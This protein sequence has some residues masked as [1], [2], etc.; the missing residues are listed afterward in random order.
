MSGEPNIVPHFDRSTLS[1]LIPHLNP[2]KSSF[3]FSFW[4]TTKILLS[5]CHPLLE[6]INNSSFAYSIVYS[7]GLAEGSTFD[8][9]KVP[10]K[11]QSRH[12]C[13]H[14]SKSLTQGEPIP[15]RPCSLPLRALHDQVIRSCS[16]EGLTNLASLDQIFLMTF[17]CV[18]D[19]QQHEY[20][21]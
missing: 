16:E 13:H 2:Y 21:A 3:K 20:F 15:L 7:A 17:F 5:W 1:Y 10:I 19:H 6:Q 9:I 14:G 12:P 4:D 8:N 18:C 11:I